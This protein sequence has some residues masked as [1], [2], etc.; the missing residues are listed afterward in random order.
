MLKNALEASHPDPTGLMVADDTPQHENAARTG[1]RVLFISRKWPP[2]VGGMET[3]CREL[4]KELARRVDLELRVLPGRPDGSI[5]SG[6]SLTLFGL[7]TAWRLLTKERGYHVVHGADVA[8]WPLVLIAKLTSPRA[9]I[10]LS[11]HGTDVSFGN[12]RGTRAFLYRIYA[13]TG[14]CLLRSASVVANS[15]AT[16]RETKRLGYARVTVVPLASR[17]VEQVPCGAPKP[18]VLFVGRHFERRKGLHWFIEKVLPL[19]PAGI[20]LNVASPPCAHQDPEAMGS[21]R[22][23]WLGPVEGPALSDLMAEALCV[24]VPNIPVADGHIEGFG[25]VAV[26]AAAAGGIV[27]AARLDGFADSVI[28]GE[29]GFLLPPMEPSTW[30]Q[31]IAEIAAYPSSERRHFVDR[32][33]AKAKRYFSWERVADEILRIYQQ[34]PECLEDQTSVTFQADN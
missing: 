33:R 4:T 16:A 32:A 5:P 15:K 30:A 17:S 22:V 23:R 18:S 34:G 1:L 26:E 2:A 31:A 13:K 9:V 27:L 24:V 20:S 7:R 14:A 10:V 11:A 21:D 12:R 28:D 25:L 29:T 6:T 8:I 19:L 3:Y